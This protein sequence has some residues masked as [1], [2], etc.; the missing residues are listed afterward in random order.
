M[1]AV[2]MQSADFS[3]V[4]QILRNF[5]AHRPKCTVSHA[6]KWQFYYRNL[7]AYVGYCHFFLYPKFH[8][9]WI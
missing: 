3:F 9:L 4:T 1:K 2:T 7:V 6:T 8:S 5:S